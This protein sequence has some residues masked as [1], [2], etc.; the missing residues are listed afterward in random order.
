MTKSK[1]L[2]WLETELIENDELD[3]D[4][5]LRDQVLDLV[6]EMREE[7]DTFPVM[8][9]S[10]DGV[11]DY[12]DGYELEPNVA[13]EIA[14][15]LA[16]RWESDFDYY[17]FMTDGVQEEIELMISRGWKGIKKIE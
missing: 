15:N 5:E 4:E 2:H 3:Q 11:R 10:A 7:R 1:L 8:W 16:N 9:I 13:I 12:A 6:H 14:R 17:T